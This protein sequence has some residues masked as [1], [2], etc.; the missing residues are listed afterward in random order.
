MFVAN[1]LAFI[2]KS[3]L[4]RGRTHAIVFCLSLSPQPDNYLER[5]ERIQMFALNGGKM[6]C[7]AKRSI[8]Q[9]QK[10]AWVWLMKL[11]IV[12]PRLASWI[13][14]S[15]KASPLCFS[16]AS[17]RRVHHNCNKLSLL[18]LRYRLLWNCEA[19]V[20]SK[21]ERLNRE[22][23]VA[24]EGKLWA[25]QREATT[26]A[27]LGKFGVTRNHENFQ[28]GPSRVTLSMIDSHTCVRSISH[29]PNSSPPIFY[30]F[31]LCQVRAKVCPKSLLL[32]NKLQSYFSTSVTEL[33]L[34]WTEFDYLHESQL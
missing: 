1:S 6:T 28:G 34:L 14:Q 17:A 7:I 8:F 10:V 3:F 9:R 19:D 24:H 13:F 4:S 27:T 25:R 5:L 18:S 2:Y 30:Q 29:S 22:K 15:L 23:R 21:R 20:K 31:S 11:Y 12:C 32:N 16:C 26:T 33:S